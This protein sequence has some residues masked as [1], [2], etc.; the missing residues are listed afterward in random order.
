MT[1]TNG[2]F[3]EKTR[4]DLAHTSAKAVL[5]AISAGVF[6]EYFS[7]FVSSP[8]EKR[9]DEWF[10][11]LYER[12]IQL[13]EL[14]HGFNLKEIFQ[15]EVFLTTFINATRYAI[16]NHQKE[17]LDAL[18]NA[19]LNSALP[20]S[21]DETRQKI[22]VRWA[23]ELSAGHI[24]ILRLF[25]EKPELI[26]VIDLSDK[27]W[28][29]NAATDKLASVIEQAYPDMEGN[30]HL[31]LQIVDDLS[32]RGLIT[33]LLPAKDMATEIKRSPVVSPI[34]KEFWQFISSPLDEK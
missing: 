4:A 19:V 23:G 14:V 21:P 13:E 12:L 25:Y 11:N 20:E 17:I 1:S 33:G 32:D 2:E 29:L 22:F 27:Q 7:H 9:R 6:G 34:G 31:Y 15:D 8:L 30:Y 3:P 28:R 16:A 26:P 10:Q 18:R 24:H 5:S